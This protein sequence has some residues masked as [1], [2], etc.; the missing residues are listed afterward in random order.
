MR[1]S[2][3]SSDVCSSDLAFQPPAVRKRMVADSLALMR[4][5]I[6]P[7]TVEADLDAVRRD[8]SIIRESRDLVGITDIACPIVLSDGRAIASIIIAYINRREMKANYEAARD[9]LRDD[10]A[11]IS[12]E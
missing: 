7:L 3:W 8:G 6:D 5:D 4:R 11:E 9:R 1:I 12:G 2:D 10:C